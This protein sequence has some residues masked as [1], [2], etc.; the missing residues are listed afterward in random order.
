M[1]IKDYNRPRGG[2]RPSRVHPDLTEKPIT[3]LPDVIVLQQKDSKYSGLLRLMRHVDVD[4]NDPQ[5][6]ELVAISF[7]S[8]TAKEMKTWYEERL[9]Q[10]S[11]HKCPRDQEFVPVYDEHDRW[12]DSIIEQRPRPPRYFRRFSDQDEHE[13][14]TL[15]LCR[16]HVEVPPDPADDEI[17]EFYNVLWVKRGEND[18]AYRVGCGRV[19]KQAWEDNNPEEIRITL[20]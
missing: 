6:I 7:G 17:V 9:F 4:H 15:A 12:V 3:L 18:I 8:A 2:V 5:P 20:G 1:A 19:L 14:L 10:M 13:I 11:A 16:K